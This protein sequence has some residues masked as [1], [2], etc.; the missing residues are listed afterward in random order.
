MVKYAVLTLLGALFVF[1]CSNQSETN[2]VEPWHG[3]AR[4][5]R[6]S[7][8]GHD[9]VIINGEKRFNRALYGSNTGF[10][11]EAGDLPEFAMYMPYIGGTLRLGVINGEDSKWLI[12]AEYI[13][14]RYNAGS[15]KYIIS[16]PILGSGK[17]HLHVLALYSAD[18]M[19][20]KIIADE[21]SESA[22]LFWAFGAAS[23]RRLS[24]GGDLGADP[25]STF[26]LK[27]EACKENKFYIR[28]NQFNL[29]YAKGRELELDE[30]VNPEEIENPQLK[31]RKRIFG[32]FPTDSDNRV[33]DAS[34]QSNPL[35]FFSSP[36]VD[37]PALT[38]R[39]KLG[40]MN[41][42]FILLMNPDS[43]DKPDVSELD[44]FFAQA[45]SSRKVIAN[46]I[47]IETPDEYINASAAQLSYASDAVW[48]GT[49]YMH[50]AVAWR[51]PLNGWRGAYTADWLG[52]HDRA[53]LHLR[54]YFAAQYTE[55]ASGPVMPDPETH[56]ARHKEVKGSAMF[57]EGYISRNPGKINKPH[58]YD[59]NLV[60]IS[61]LL[62]HFKWTGDLDFLRESWPVIER[63]M[64]WEKRV[65]DGNNDGLYDSY[66]SIWASDA[67]QYSGGGV[68]Y[69]SAY[70]YRANVE[71]ARLASLIGENPYPYY[72][73]AERIKRAVNKHLWLPEK[74]WFAEY[75]DL[76]GKQLVHTSPGVWSIYHTIDEGLAN[77]FQA[78]QSTR[79]IDHNIPHI[80]IVAEN[81]PEGN[82][83]TIST[84]NWM[85]YTWSINSVALAEVMHTALAYWKAGR[86]QKAFE[87]TKSSFL[88]YMYLGSSPGNFGQLSFYDAFRGELYRDFADPI[89]MSSRALIEGLFGIQPNLLSK[90]LRIEPGWPEEWHFAKLE[91]PD[92]KMHYTKDGMI[93]HFL[94][95][96]HFPTALKL[97]LSLYAKADKVK[98]VK[99]NGKDASWRSVEDA[100]GSPKI[101]LV[102]DIDKSFEVEIE[103]EGNSL[104]SFDDDQVFALGE[105]Q[106]F[107]FGNALVLKLKDPQGVFYKPVLNDNSVEALLQGETGLRTAFV[108]LKQG[109][110]TWWQSVTFELK[111]VVDF[112]ADEE[113]KNNETQ[114]TLCNNT[115]NELRG[116]VQIHNFTENISL[117]PGKSTVVSVP[118][119]E[120]IPG[121]NRVVFEAENESF[122]GEFIQWN[123]PE[124]EDVNYET[125]ALQPW[126][127]DR[128]TNIFTEQYYLP[129]SPYTT[130]SIPVQGI[131]DWCS[132]SETADIDDTGLRAAAGNNGI[133][134][135]PQGIPFSISE[136]EE[137]NIVFT[138]QWDN[139]PQQTSID[140]DGKASHLYLLMAGSVHHMQIRMENATVTVRYADGT[141]DKLPL[142]SPDNWWPI[143][144]DYYID[145]HAFETG[146]PQP[147]R[148]HLKTGEWH[149]DSYDVL[150]VNHTIKI[151][152][153]A[154]SLLDL[155]LNPDKELKSLSL[156]THTNDVVVGLMGATLLRL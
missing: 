61:Q 18:G 58:H 60:F 14:A 147:P 83:Y 112:T 134:K 124:I 63:H 131:G 139:Y 5:M 34:D 54:G 95:E 47:K 120:L 82:Y 87:L 76:L 86:K 46:H 19:V 117:Q 2:K 68:V 78:Y 141:E 94:I 50:G 24:R 136:K 23:G 133:V 137:T 104:P 28:D 92:L 75:K 67:V 12:D 77:P 156:E 107:D 114:I 153:G 6:Y 81:M 3:Q 115:G 151:D 33:S 31:T 102:S 53:R 57:T 119:S 98:T 29:Y 111:Q 1:G 149:M 10:R 121:T 71:V 62:W 113:L 88:D 108:K 72:E 43:G 56:L 99:V 148:L 80:P 64:A 79:F 74:G 27:P 4:E 11:A 101:E 45:D 142:I 132:Y 116:N 91:T 90:S 127:N 16:D 49:S 144:Q 25:E 66:C 65:F 21:I 55:P 143:E 70:N 106:T 73:E 40:A 9:F 150:A 69:S 154:A 8:D 138:S 93:D 145:G 155:P 22:E 42:E 37:A 85:P 118:V 135:S 105:K 59:M 100:V 96:S 97:V 128:V 15:M 44:K 109:D 84:T 36:A 126:F 103:W 146:K 129:R 130:V 52:W 51:M 39:A 152:G 17:L 125:V 89:G 32:I 122:A 38:G 7:P 123:V 30:G 35:T 110:L 41:E 48:D 140:L 13:E 20:L 26:Y